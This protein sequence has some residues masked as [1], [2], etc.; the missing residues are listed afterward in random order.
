MDVGLRL[1]GITYVWLLILF[2]KT[3]TVFCDSKPPIHNTS[4]FWIGFV[5]GWI[6]D[7]H[8]KQE[9]DDLTST[10]SLHNKSFGEF[11]IVGCCSDTFPDTN[12]LRNL[13]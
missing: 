6:T 9:V 7:L 1:D 3:Y 12:P 8:Y 11:M 10:L 5:V 13:S 4:F 2:I